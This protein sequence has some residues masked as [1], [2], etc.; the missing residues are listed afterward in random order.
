VARVKESEPTAFGISARTARALSDPWR[1]RI[2]TEVTVRPLSPSQFVDQI[3]GELTHVSRCFRQLAEWGY[4]EVVEER[5]GRRRGA[6]IEHVYRAIRRAHFDISTWK[7]V[8]RSGRDSVSRAILDSYQQ[9]IGAAM[10]GGTFDQEA[11]RHLSWDTVALDRLAWKQLGVRLDEVLDSLADREVAAQ[12]RFVGRAE[13]QIP[14][15]VGLAAFRSPDYPTVKL[16]GLEQTGPAEELELQ[17]QYVLGPKLAKALSNKWRCRILMEVSV[18]PLS[19]SQF[20]EEFGGS[21]TH[22]SRCFRDLASWGYLEVFEERNGGRRGGGVERIYR[23]T[24]RP[25]FDGP[26]WE[27]L[28]LMIREEMSEWFLRTYFD[29]VSEAINAGTFDADLDRHLSWKPIVVDRQAW[30]EVGADLD[31]VLGWLPQL[32]GESLDRESD[33]D[34]LIPTTVGLASFRSPQKS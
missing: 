26:T 28:P 7:D 17:P 22:I 10:E 15:T 23:S 31:E 19:P 11:D 25:Y 20:V 16:R 1:F 3:G 8:P 30:K 9:R 14:A 32:E 33:F 13:P 21:M 34:S 4:L 12:H 5:P 2:L 27:N 29:R 18:R 24:R 6:A